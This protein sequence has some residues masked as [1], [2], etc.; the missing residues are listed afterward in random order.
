MKEIILKKVSIYK[1]SIGKHLTEI[2]NIY[3]KQHKDSFQK[4]KWKTGR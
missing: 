4:R 3:V 2:V 1:T